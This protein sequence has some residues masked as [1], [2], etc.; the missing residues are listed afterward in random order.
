MKFLSDKELCRLCEN[1]SCAVAVLSA[2]ELELLSANCSEVSLKKGDVL[3]KEGALTSHIVYLKTGLVKES[4]NGA[5]NKEQIIQLIKAHSYLGLSSMIGY[6]VSQ[7]TY[8]ALEDLK[9]CYIDT[10]VFKQL[11]L[12]NGRFSYEILV[13]VCRENLN[14]YNR[15]LNKSIKQL[16]G[17]FADAMLYFSNIIYESDTFELPVT[18]NELAALISTTRESVTRTFTKFKSEGI[19]VIND[20][21]ITILKKELL[22]QISKT[23]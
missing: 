12:S 7:Y 11:V 13:S 1:K 6:H 8:T 5:N 16:Y 23:G 14:N 3:F 21:K 18:Q 4:I 15:C 20:R 2:D 19:L 17:R 10:S 22:E 9:V